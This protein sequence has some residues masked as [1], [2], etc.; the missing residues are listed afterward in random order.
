MYPTSFVDCNGNC[1]NDTDGDGMCDELEVF[2]CTDPTNPGYNPNATDDDG[3]CLV[4]GCVFTMACNYDPNADYMIP[5][6]CDFTSCQGCTDENACNYDEGS[7]IDD[8][9]CILPQDGYDCDGN[10]L[11]DSDGDG[12]CDEFEIYG[13]TDPNNPSYSPF[14]T[15]DDGSCL[16]GGCALPFACNYDPDADYTIIALCD[17]TSCLGCTDEEACNYDPDATLNNNTCE[18][19]EEYY[20]CEGNCINDADGDGICDE[21]EVLGC[22]DP[23]NPGYDPE[24]TEDD[25]SCLVGGCTI[26]F[27]CNFD[28]TA[29]YLIVTDCEFTSCIGCTDPA[30]CNYDPDATLSNNASC[31]YPDTFYDCDGFCEND[32]DG[33]GVCDELEVFGCTD[34]EAINYNPE[35]TEDN[36]TCLFEEVGGCTLPFACNYDED[37]DYYIPGS[38]DFSCLFGLPQGAMNCFDPYAC[39]FGEEGDCVYVDEDGELCVNIGCTIPSACNFDPEAE[40]N[41]D[42]CEFLSCLGCMDVTACDFDPEATISGS[43]DYVSCQGCMDENADNFDPDATIADNSSCIYY[44]CTIPGACNFDPMANMFDNSCEFESC[45]GCMNP[46]AC[47]YDPD[48]VYQGA[49]TFPEPGFDCDGACLNDVDGDG[50]CDEDEVPGCD[51]PSADNYEVDASDND[52][53]CEYT[54]PGCMEADACNYNLMATEDD[55]SC[56]YTS[57]LGCTNVLAC[58]YDPTAIYSDPDQCEWP[59]EYYDCDGICLDDVDGD[60]VCD[61][62]EIPGCTDESA[63]NYSEEA[64]DDDGSCIPT[65]TGCTDPVA[66]NYNADANVD[67]GSCEM[68]SCTGCMDPIA[69]NYDS[70]AIYAGECEYPVEGYDCDGVCINDA[71]GDGVCDEFEEPGC[72]DSD[73]CNYNAD[74]TDDDGTC[75]YVDTDYYNCD[76]S[77]INDADGDGVCDEFEVGGCDDLCA[78]NYDAEVTDNDGSCDYDCSGC[79]YSTAS[80]Y[81]ETAMYDDGSCEFEGCTDPQF[82]NYNPMANVMGDENCS[83]SPTFADFSGD[84]V[85]EMDDL[86]QFLTA[87]ASNAPDFNGLEWAQDACDITPIDDETLLEGVGFGEGDPA[88]ACYVNEGCM[89]AGAINYDP[90]AESDAG[91]CV[92]AGCTDSTAINYNAIA[93]VDDGTCKYQVCPDFNGDGVVQ[94]SDLLDFLTTWGTIYSE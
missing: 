7:T 71:D 52:G 48:A 6:S 86:L 11:N 34:E 55:G 46:I 64:T 57:C 79:T 13:C 61:I 84:G 66:C 35:A 9:S 40:F 51:D 69:C 30:A 3:S 88:A 2:G 38:C 90:A 50:G 32:T 20:D 10:C 73:A 23:T 75:E 5:G 59:D 87:Y 31:E 76:G 60:G 53:S 1:V 85:V 68:E 78:C 28:P 94:A 37:A 81:D 39:N 49:C 82:A 77:C 21:F 67:D 14:A 33:D 26:P 44:G 36:G 80:N 92:F 24:A 17:F 72:T 29:D 62:F 58:N 22:T 74:A 70:E 89:Y 63:F 45:V 8:G 16:E 18:Y 42:S 27:A 15:E 65:V 93:N 19:P 83:N 43:C 56:E 25:G 12:V 4:G 41:D 91:F 47:D 54:I